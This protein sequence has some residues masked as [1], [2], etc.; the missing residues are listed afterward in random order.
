MAAIHEG[1]VGCQQLNGSDL[2]VIALPHGCPLEAIRFV[3]RVAHARIISDLT[4]VHDA[5]KF[6][7]RDPCRLTEIELA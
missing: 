3:S 7:V 5:A 2:D 6:V 1:C 4:R